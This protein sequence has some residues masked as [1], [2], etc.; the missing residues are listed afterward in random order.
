MLRIRLLLLLAALS[1]TPA[2]SCGSE[3]TTQNSPRVQTGETQAAPAATTPPSGDLMEIC[4]NLPLVDKEA[5]SARQAPELMAEGEQMSIPR[6]DPYAWVNGQD[7]TLGGP[8]PELIQAGVRAD[9][10]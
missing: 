5:C 1:A 3:V 2:T 4:D 6:C 7:K 8:N 9:M 10:G